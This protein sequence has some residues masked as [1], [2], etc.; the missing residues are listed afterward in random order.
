MSCWDSP[1]NPIDC[2]GTGHDGDIQAG[3]ELSYTDTGLTIIDNNTKLEWMKQ[4]NNNLGCGSLP[5]SLDQDCLFTWD[6]AFA[7]VAKL[8][9]AEFAGHTDWRMPNIKELISI[10]NYGARAPAV[11][12]AF[13]IGCTSGCLLTTCSCTPAS[14]G[15]F[16]WSSTTYGTRS[17]AWR[18]G[19]YN[20]G[21]NAEPISH[22]R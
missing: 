17:W 5:G 12:E 9:E 14:A 11:S 16:Y 3:A 22:S 2:A 13:N 21:L 7:F 19:I 15:T 20:G 18:L 8:N 6:E 4:D 1:G 10:V